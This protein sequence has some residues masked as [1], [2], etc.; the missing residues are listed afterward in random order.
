[1]NIYCAAVK[2]FANSFSPALSN[3]RPRDGLSSKYRR[4][5][6]RIRHPEIPTSLESL[7]DLD[8]LD[9]S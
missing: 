6:N 3:R 2:Q 7:E 9:K 8:Y 1:M 5:P 4:T